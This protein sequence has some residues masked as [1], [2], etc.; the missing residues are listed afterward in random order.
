MADSTQNP[1][2]VFWKL[3]EPIHA[4]T[5]FAQACR[6][7]FTEVGLK[8]FWMGYFA[9]RAAPLGACHASTVRATFYNF[10]PS[11]VER[12]IPGA[13]ARAAPAT[14]LAARAESASIALRQISPDV[15]EHTRRICPLLESAVAAAQCDGRVL[16]AANQA[17]ELS[18][19]PVARV[20]QAATTLRE[21]R[22]D[23]HVSL[24]VGAG[25][26]GIQAHLLQVGAGHTTSEVIRAARRWPDSEWE[27]A[28]ES[29][30]SRGLVD[31]DGTLTVEGAA[32][33][34]HI[35]DTTDQLA[36]QP[37]ADGLTESGLDLLATVLRPLSKAV[38]RSGVVP[39]P[40]A[41]AL[42]TDRAT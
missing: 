23:G 33:H 28:H 29:L 31:P 27:A 36:L 21:H 30:V 40:N 34:L 26:S 16:A 11:E 7:G 22:G 5:Y 6:D 19:D 20:W 9:G 41:M 38:V 2:R 4:V 17:L 12:A 25:I 37:F 42:G 10:A 3:M 39:F 8:G 24:L 32:M 1:A 14:V 18:D 13:W 35:E 15:A